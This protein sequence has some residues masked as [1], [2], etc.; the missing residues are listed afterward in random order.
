MILIVKNKPSIGLALSKMPTISEGWLHLSH[1]TYIVLIL[2]FF[3]I[4]LFY[5]RI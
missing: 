4:L 1:C 2:Q 5:V 3:Y